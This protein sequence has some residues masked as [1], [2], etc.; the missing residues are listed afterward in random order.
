MVNE[1][2]DV[3]NQQWNN[4]SVVVGTE[5]LCSCRQTWGF[6][7]VAHTLYMSALEQRV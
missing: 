3:D 5:E 6:T 1:K 2:A 7:G 4:G